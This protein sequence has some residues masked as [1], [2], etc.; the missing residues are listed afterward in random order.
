MRLTAE[1]YETL[2]LE[3]LNAAAKANIMEQ[4]KHVGRAQTFATLALTAATMMPDRTKGYKE[5]EARADGPSG[6]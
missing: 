6:V 3:E 2:A 1:E 5:L 4:L